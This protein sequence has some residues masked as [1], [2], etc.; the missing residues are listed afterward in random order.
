MIPAI[1]PFIAVTVI[2]LSGCAKKDIMPDKKPEIKVTVD[3][4]A[5][6]VGESAVVTVFS[7]VEMAEAV[8]FTVYSD[9]KNIIVPEYEKLIME[10]GATKAKVTITGLAAGKTTVYAESVSPVVDMVKSKLDISVHSET[11]IIKGNVE[12]FVDDVGIANDSYLII[13]FE[14]K[15]GSYPVGELLVH[16]YGW[17]EDSDMKCLSLNNYGLAFVGEK[18]AEGLHFVAVDKGDDMNSLAWTENPL[19]DKDKRYENIPC[20]CSPDMESPLTGE[21]YVAFMCNYSASGDKD[22]EK[23]YRVWMRLNVEKV[24][25]GDFSGCEASLCLDSNKVFKVG[26]TE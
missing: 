9:D 13:S 23:A 16:P 4:T 5:I 19:Y 6:K 18:D 12:A 25:D 3:R 2:F 21:I 22:D 8:E 1:V 7:D 15:G 20:I 10:K 17:D 11:T 24:M 26:Q 14:S